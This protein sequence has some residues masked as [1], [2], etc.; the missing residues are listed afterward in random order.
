MLGDMFDILGYIVIAAVILLIVY[1]IV[2]RSYSHPLRISAKDASTLISLGEINRIVD[3]RTEMEWNRGHFPRAIHLPLA[4]INENTAKAVL[5]QADTILVYCNSGTRARQAATK[6]R[7][8]GYPNV[9]YVAET[10]HEL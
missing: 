1:V 4:S 5:D 6:L 3:V 9:Y 8:L 2:E 7:D 10:Y